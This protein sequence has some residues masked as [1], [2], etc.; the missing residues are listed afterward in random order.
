MTEE[1]LACSKSRGNDLSTPVPEIGYPGLQPGDRWCLCA[2]RWK[3][4]LDTGVA[5]PVILTAKEALAYVSLEGGMQSISSDRRHP[6]Y[7]RWRE[8]SA[9]GVGGG[10]GAG[11]PDRTAEPSLRY[12]KFLIRN[13]DAVE[14]PHEVARQ[15][16]CRRGSAWSGKTAVR[17]E[18]AGTGTR[19]FTGWPPGVV[20]RPGRRPAP[21]RRRT[22]IR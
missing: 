15:D 18:A 1:F 19:T 3:E 4:A 7:R 16:E 2:A 22:P 14:R 5:L 17:V 8:L 20:V 6:R 21:T 13:A 11:A 10:R 9:V 12:P